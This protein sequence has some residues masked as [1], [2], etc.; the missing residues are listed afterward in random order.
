MARGGGF[1]RGKGGSSSRSSARASV[2]GVGGRSRSLAAG[3]RRGRAGEHYAPPHAVHK[4]NEYRGFSC[5]S[6][7]SAAG[8]F[9]AEDANGGSVGGV[10]ASGVSGLLRK[11]PRSDRAR[12]GCSHR[13]RD[14]GVISDQLCIPGF[15]QGENEHG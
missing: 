2:G 10:H 12:E 1:V 14:E 13:S 3:L 4:S 5:D 7:R 6:R 8:A 15:R 11:I 9:H